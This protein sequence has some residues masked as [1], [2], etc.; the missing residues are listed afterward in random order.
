L[1]STCYKAE[2]RGLEGIGYGGEGEKLLPPNTTQNQTKTGG[3]RN[4]KP[5]L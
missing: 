4:F 1:G 5:E 3:V 2:K